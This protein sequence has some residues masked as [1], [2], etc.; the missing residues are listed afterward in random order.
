MS[1]ALA[2]LQPQRF[3]RASADASVTLV[4]DVGRMIALLVEDAAQE[5]PVATALLDALE[6]M[7]PRLQAELEVRFRTVA[8]SLRIRAQGLVSSLTRLGDDIAAVADDATRALALGKQL[9]DLL[10][11]GLQALTYP[12]LRA[13]VQF[14]VDLLERDLGLSAS[15]IEAQ[16]LAFLNDAATRVAAL[17]TGA[18][19]ALRRKRRTIAATLRRL[20]HF[21]EERFHFPGFDVDG[22]ARALYDLLRKAGVEEMARQLRCALREFE[23]AVTS[24]RALREIAT[25]A[26]AVGGGSVGAAALVELESQPV[27][28]WYPSWLLGDEDLPLIG[29]S[30]LTSAAGLIVTIRDSALEVP[31]WLREQLSA[32]QLGAFEGVALGTEPTE[33][34][35]LTVLAVLNQLIQGPLIY[36]GERFPTLSLP[37][38]LLSD[39]HDAIEDNAVLLANRR[40]IC[41]AFQGF[42]KDADGG[43]VRWLGRS[44]LGALDWPRNQVS[45]SADRRFVLCDDMP[46]CMGENLSWTDAPIFSKTERGQTFWIF[47]H[48]SPAV[49]EGFAHHLAWP[50]TLGKAVWHLVNT[51]LDQP[52]HRVGSA[53]AVSLEFAEALNQLIFGRPVNGYELG[54]FGNWLSSGA[55]GPRAVS[56]LAGSFQGFHTKATGG[57]IFLFW[58]TML[59]GDVIRTVGPSSLLGTVREVVLGVLTLVNFGGPRDAPSTL[60]PSPAQNHLK[61]GP[62]NSL[63]NSLF[64]LWLISYYEREDHAVEIW[65]KGGIGEQRERAFKLWLGGGIGMGI[66]AGVT[67]TLVA[68]I[69][70]WAEDWA[71]FGK[72][73]GMASLTMVLQFWF[74]EY[75]QKEGDTDGGTYNPRGPRAFKGY[76]KKDTSPYRLPFPKGESLYCGQGNQG[77]WS[78]NDIA[79]I[80]SSQQTYAYDFGHDHE[81]GIRA[82]R[83]GIVWAFTESNADNDTSAPN[84]I[85][86]LHDQSDPEHDDPF[87]TGPVTTYARYLHGAQNG[88]TNAF[89]SRGLAAPVAESSSPGSGTRVNRGDLIMLADDTGKSFHSHLHMDVMMDTSGTVVAPGAA[90]GPGNVGIPFVFAEVR[91]EGRP[92]NLTWYESENG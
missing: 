56:I 2:I 53:V 76:P 88:V 54:G 22:L 92:L 21:L 52:G 51:I 13:Q 18:D 67:T 83:G 70:A 49:C 37:E 43:F 8:G 80:G 60:P 38:D 48:V 64:G 45:V 23:S 34:Q 75:F 25:A 14:A 61:Q 16:L 66:A 39:Q 69:M 77:L 20:A 90:N 55:V 91:G 86:I 74:L 82:A 59:A 47:E 31:R 17:D 9:L 26:A 85:T 28:A 3:S 79:N 50:T 73:V 4:D 15:F 27:Y 71:R 41:H 10:E 65:S 81:Q 19:A 40:F 58:I 36:D 7:G 46:L 89:T 6:A 57:N 84:T 1:L 12:G 62:I 29:L 5:G 72:T 68:Q 78:H 11:S 30:D 42:V 63:V 35:K 24:A 44:T 87:G 32:A 33:E